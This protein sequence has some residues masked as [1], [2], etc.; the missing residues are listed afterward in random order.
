[1]ISVRLACLIHAASVRSE[2]ESNSPF[3]FPELF[4]TQ[5]LFLTIQTEYSQNWNAVFTAS[6]PRFPQPLWCKINYFKLRLAAQ[7]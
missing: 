7:N 6:Q 5:L 2:P 4:I 1:M 3:K